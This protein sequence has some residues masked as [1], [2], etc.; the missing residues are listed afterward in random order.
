MN[1]SV[2]VLNAIINANSPIKESMRP[3]IAYPLGVLNTA[4]MLNISPRIHKTTFK[5]G[6]QQRTIAKTASTNPA[7]PTLF[8]DWSTYIICW[9]LL[10]AT[11]GSV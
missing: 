9:S 1:K 6:I 4:A 2:S 5:P 10:C 7:V 11:L 3:V 8:P